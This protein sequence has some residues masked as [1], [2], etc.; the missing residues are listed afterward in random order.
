[1]KLLDHKIQFKYDSLLQSINKSLF[2]IKISTNFSHELKNNPTTLDEA[3]SRDLIQCLWI[4]MNYFF[5][6]VICFASC[7]RHIAL[8]SVQISTEFKFF[9]LNNAWCPFEKVTL[10]SGSQRSDLTSA[11]NEHVGLVVRRFGTE[12]WNIISRMDSTFSW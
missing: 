12:N 3:Q 1:M 2:R 6:V 4:L 10:I 7:S 5:F 9:V 8:N 11:L